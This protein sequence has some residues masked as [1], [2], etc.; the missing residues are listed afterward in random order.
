MIS[1]D[2]IK[3]L[4]DIGFM[5]SSSGCSKHAFAI[6][7]GIEVARPDNVLPDIGYAMEFMNRKKYQEAIS[8]LKKQAL[9]KDPDNVAVKAFIGMALM[10]D[11]HNKESEECLSEIENCDDSATAKMAKEL[12]ENVRSN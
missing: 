1:D 11:G 3:T 9:V 10:L 2:M 5:A 4:A 12:L 6:F 7:S 8:V